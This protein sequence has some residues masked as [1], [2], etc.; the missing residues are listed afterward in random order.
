M[1]IKTVL[2]DEERAAMNGLQMQL[3]DVS[4]NVD[5]IGTACGIED[6]YHMIIEFKP[7]LIFLDTKF[8]N[9]TGFDLLRKFE[10]INFKVVF[11]TTNEKDVIE[12]SKMDAVDYLLKPIDCRALNLAV[13]K[14][15]KSFKDENRYKQMN[16]MVRSYFNKSLKKRKLAIKESKSINY[17]DIDDIMH[18]KAD[19]NYTNI[20]LRTGKNYVSSKVLKHYDNLL[21]EYGFLRVH[22]SNMVNLNYVKEFKHRY[23]GSIVLQNDDEISI[24][25]DKKKIFFD[26]LGMI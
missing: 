1:K 25:P 26:R 5:I 12:V 18:L 17:I 21:S 14:V 9:G 10:K 3:K 11:T 4:E 19:G 8:T 16:S 15:K 7:D 23:G 20:V 2:I 13:S 6:G 24:A 22:R